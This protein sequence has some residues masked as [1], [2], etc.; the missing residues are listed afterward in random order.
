MGF[1]VATGLRNAGFDPLAQ[2]L[3]LKLRKDGQETGHGPPGR[4]GEI[5]GFVERDKP[6][7]QCVQLVQRIHQIDD[8]PSP[9]IQPPDHNRINLASSCGPHEL[10][11][12][13]PLT[14]PRPYLGNRHDN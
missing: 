13:L 12:L 1:A 3:P 9:S 8:G 4:R 10:V 5:Q 6:H 11:A 7:A 14:D 2:N